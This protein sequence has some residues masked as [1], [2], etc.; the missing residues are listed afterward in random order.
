MTQM[1]NHKIIKNFSRFAKHYDAHSALQQTI[2]Q[3]LLRALPKS[4]APKQILEI[5]CG[6][7]H[8]TQ[9]LAQHFPDSQ[10]LATDITPA[11]LTQVRQKT[12]A[13]NIQTMPLNG[14]D[15]S[16]LTDQKFD[17]IISNMSA[18]WLKNL[19]ACYAHWQG[20]LTHQG[21]I[22]TSRPAQNCV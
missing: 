10:I 14:E 15:L 16:A 5:G 9:M 18:Q 3:E 12:N 17:L 7:G 2:A 20:H 8:L 11:M 4:A 22:L 21:I 19:G 13:A 1:H 6:T